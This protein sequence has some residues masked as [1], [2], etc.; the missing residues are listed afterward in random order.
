MSYDIS[1]VDK[2]TGRTIHNTTNHNISGT[3]YAMNGTDE[4]WINISYNYRNWF[5]KCFK[6]D[7]IHFLEGK[8]S[9]ETWEPL[10]KALVFL[11]SNYD[12]KD[13]SSDPWSPESGDAYD[14]IINLLNLAYIAP[15]GVWEIT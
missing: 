14:M 8:V 12:I 2:Y 7:G 5:M 15:D 6:N 4:L 9:S 10:Q 11:A 1:L 3:T 13:C